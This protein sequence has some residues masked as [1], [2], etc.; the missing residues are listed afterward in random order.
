MDVPFCGGKVA[1]HESWNTRLA[2]ET[3]VGVLQNAGGQEIRQILIG[4]NK[5][6]CNWGCG[7][8]IGIEEC[9]YECVT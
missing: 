4:C 2:T 5:Y 8:I 1:E 6:T 3:C 7:E 9:L